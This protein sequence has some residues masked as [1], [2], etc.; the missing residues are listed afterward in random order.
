MTSAISVGPIRASPPQIGQ[1]PTRCGSPAL[2][3]PPSI[4]PHPRKVKLP[5]NRLANGVD[6]NKVLPIKFTLPIGKAVFA[7][8]SI[9]SGS[10]VIPVKIGIPKILRGPLLPVLPT[11]PGIHNKYRVLREQCIKFHILTTTLLPPLQKR[12]KRFWRVWMD[13]GGI[14]SLKRYKIRD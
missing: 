5:R 4:G 11:K 2:I 10:S 9:S 8:I 14:C 13:T 7:P 12:V 6:K 3:S 1:P